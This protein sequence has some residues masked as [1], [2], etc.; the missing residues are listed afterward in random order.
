MT[1]WNVAA[2]GETDFSTALADAD[3]FGILGRERMFS[4][5]RWTAADSTAPAYQAL[6][7]LPKL[8]RSASH[9]R[10]DFG[11]GDQRCHRPRPVQQLCG[12][13]RSRHHA[14]GTGGQQEPERNGIDGDQPESL[15]G[16]DSDDLHALASLAH[17]NC[18]WNVRGIPGDVFF[19]AL[20]GDLAGD[21][22]NDGSG[23]GRRVGPE[24]GHDH[25]AG[26][27]KRHAVT[28]DYFGHGYSDV[29]FAAVGRRHYR[30][31]DPT[32][33]DRHAWHGDGD[34]WATRRASIT[35]P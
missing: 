32:Q 14:D 28:E 35:T 4:A 9:F 16:G 3:V 2:A 21:Q 26:R 29:E 11:F 8:R 12:D 20:F 33:R 17:V 34:R 22:R 1:E 10:A 18:G 19:C 24:S 7:L 5:S 31:A 30:R 25:G 6:K 27:R 15:H 13:Q 23:T